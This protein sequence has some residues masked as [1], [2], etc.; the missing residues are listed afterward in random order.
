MFFSAQ[1]NK[2]C[3][4][5]FHQDHNIY[6]R[7][8]KCR[9][10][11]YLH[12]LLKLMNITFLIAKIKRKISLYEYKPIAYNILCKNVFRTLLHSRCHVVRHHLQPKKG[13]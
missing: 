9:K 8:E 11:L 2:C 3:S 6:Y 13:V 5:D 12:E 7:A 10:R 4:L 1:K